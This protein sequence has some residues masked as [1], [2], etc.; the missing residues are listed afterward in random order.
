M[1]ALL[2]TL[3][4][5]LGGIAIALITTN[6]ATEAV[7]RSNEVASL[8]LVDKTSEVLY[9]LSEVRNTL[10][11]KRVLLLRIENGTLTDMKSNKFVSV[12]AESFGPP[13]RS[14][15]PLFQKYPADDA[16]KNMVTRLVNKDS[17]MLITEEMELGFLRTYYLAVGVVCS[18]VFPIYKR[19]ENI[20][21]F[22]SVSFLSMRDENDPMFALMVDRMKHEISTILSILPEVGG[23]NPTIDK[24]K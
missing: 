5:V 1:I 10:E 2:T 21:W 11:A 22:G 17:H 13:M 9:L 7:K 24:T 3:I 18:Y 6:K 14:S 8:T 20:L 23:H 12:V 16:Y 4:S 19:D 15:K